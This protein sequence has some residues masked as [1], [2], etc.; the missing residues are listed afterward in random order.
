MCASWPRGRAI[1]EPYET[2]N[3]PENGGRTRTSRARVYTE[4]QEKQEVANFQ[5]AHFIPATE[6]A[7]AKSDDAV[8]CL[9]TGA[10]RVTGLGASK[11]RS[12]VQLMRRIRDDG[13]RRFGFSSYSVFTFNVSEK[14]TPAERSCGVLRCNRL[15]VIEAS[16]PSRILL[17]VSMCAC[18][19]RARGFRCCD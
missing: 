16:G 11:I 12:N 8:I 18:L 3:C 14:H 19:L 13:L 5:K 1:C 7:E 10:H 9:L 17:C 6:E 15:L 4:G 2:I